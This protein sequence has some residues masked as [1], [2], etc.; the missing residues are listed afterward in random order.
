MIEFDCDIQDKLKLLSD[1]E[2]K[3][4]NIKN[5]MSDIEFDLKER[6]VYILNLLN[7]TDKNI[8]HINLNE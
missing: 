4:K 1:N 3:K 5:I 6:K 2:C 7:S 8:V